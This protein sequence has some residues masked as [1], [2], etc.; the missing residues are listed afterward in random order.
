M[1][2][3]WNTKEKKDTY[4]D[5]A[6]IKMDKYKA[7]LK[8]IGSPSKLWKQYKRADDT[9]HNGWPSYVNENWTY[10]VFFQFVCDLVD[11]LVEVIDRAEKR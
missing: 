1:G 4:S 11:E 6:K 10:G 8:K 7:E 3:F 2:W 5:N 9:D